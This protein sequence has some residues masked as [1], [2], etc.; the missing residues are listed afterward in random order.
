LREVLKNI[1]LRR[2][3]SMIDVHFS[4]RTEKTMFLEFSP[5]ERLLYQE[6]RR[7]DTAVGQSN[8]PLTCILRLRMIC[9]HG[10]D[11]IPQLYTSSSLPAQPGKTCISCGQLILRHMQI[12]GAGCPHR[13]LCERCIDLVVDL[14]IQLENCPQC[15]LDDASSPQLPP[16]P[17]CNRSARPLGY[18][19]PST[20]V[21]ALVRNIQ[22]ELSGTQTGSSTSPKHI[23]FSQWTRMLDLI[24]YAL[25]DVGLK[26]CRLDGSLTRR[27]RDVALGTFKCDPER[28]VLLISLKAG[29]VGLNLTF[30]SRAHLVEPHWNPMVELQALDRVHRIGQK[31]DVEIT[32]YVVK[33]TIEMD[34]LNCQQKKIKLAEQS[35][36]AGRLQTDKINICKEIVTRYFPSSS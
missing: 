32:R 12:E 35:L 6:A 30:A 3:K 21:L 14:Q 31:K 27:Q 2:T 9:N 5:A 22:R 10:N 17:V 4:K 36:D 18:Q 29:G 33:N 11:L 1:C 7:L 26:Y 25:D 34:M 8:N 16:E 24:E 19:G 15:D 20:K 13:V 23:V 28:H